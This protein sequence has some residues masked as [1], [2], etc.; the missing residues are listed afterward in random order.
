M[1]GVR[2]TTSFYRRGVPNAF[3]D[4]AAIAAG[5]YNVFQPTR[6]AFNSGFFQKSISNFI[7]VSR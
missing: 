3:H 1:P 5:N 4:F 7:S 6:P 2:T